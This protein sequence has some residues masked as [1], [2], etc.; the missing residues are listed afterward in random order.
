MKDGTEQITASCRKAA[1]VVSLQL[2]RALFNSWDLSCYSSF[3]FTVSE[4]TAA[5]VL[6]TLYLSGSVTLQ[7]HV[8]DPWRRFPRLHLD[9]RGIEHHWAGCAIS[10]G[11]KK[12]KKEKSLDHI[13]GSDFLLAIVWEE[14]FLL[15]VGGNISSMSHLMDYSSLISINLSRETT[16]KWPKFQS[17][18]GHLLWENESSETKG[19]IN[20]KR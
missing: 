15:S 10:S 4:I 20:C 19:S 2:I 14:W 18:W 12:K 6:Q 7:R 8:W 3:I 16:G 13:I 5:S 11:V 1:P 9:P 17:V